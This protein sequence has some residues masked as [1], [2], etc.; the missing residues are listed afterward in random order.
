MQRLAVLHIWKM[1][2]KIYGNLFTHPADSIDMTIWAR[3]IKGLTPK[4][5]ERGLDLLIEEGR[6]FPPTAPEFRSLCRA[7]ESEQKEKLYQQVV[8]W[9]A[10]SDEEK[11]PE[12]LFIV[13]NLDL[14]SF[15]R[16]NIKRARGMFEKAYEQLEAHIAAGNELPKPPVMIED[17]NYD[18][19]KLQDGF[20]A[21][22]IQFV[23]RSK[24]E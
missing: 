21:S 9:S 7:D 1:L 4:Q 17:K 16:A 15:R 3:A 6:K 11:T 19:R 24:H 20:I 18:E 23:K 22:L 12:G 8:N 13:R 2:S 10:L 14:F 5:V